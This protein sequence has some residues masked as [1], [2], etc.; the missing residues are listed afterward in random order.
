MLLPIL[1]VKNH[2]H[3]GGQPPVGVGQRAAAPRRDV[4]G[5]RVVRRGQIGQERFADGGSVSDDEIFRASDHLDHDVQC[6]A[7]V[8]VQV[9]H[10]PGAAGVLVA[11]IAAVRLIGHADRQRV[12]AHHARRVVG[13]VVSHG[14]GVDD[15]PVRGRCQVAGLLAYLQIGVRHLHVRLVA[16]IARFVVGDGLGDLGS[17]GEGVVAMFVQRIAESAGDS[18]HAALALRHLIHVPGVGVA[19]ADSLGDGHVA[20]TDDV[21]HRHADL[22]HVG[23][24]HAGGVARASV[25]KKRAQLENLC[26]NI[27]RYE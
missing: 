22:N 8:V 15:V 7:V 26:Y 21:L 1:M 25:G 27:A 23:D 4:G 5:H 3:R 9:A 17:V 18:D 2:L 11:P 24:R 13:A 19:A 14:E 6:G 10:V 16:V 20:V 12:A